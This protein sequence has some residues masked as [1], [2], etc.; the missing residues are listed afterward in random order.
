MLFGPT[1]LFGFKLDMILDISFLL[2]GYK[3][4][5]VR[6]IV[7]HVFRR[8]FIRLNYISLFSATEKIAH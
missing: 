6:G 8:M 2:V 4:A 5:R 7:F 1:D 3:L